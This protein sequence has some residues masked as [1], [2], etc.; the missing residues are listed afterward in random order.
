MSQSHIVLHL[1]HW[2]ENS[3]LICSHSLF[4]WRCR[5]Y[6]CEMAALAESTANSDSNI[7]TATA[8]EALNT[9]DT[10]QSIYRMSQYRFECDTISVHHFNVSDGAIT[11]P[12][13][14]RFAFSKWILLKLC[15]FRFNLWIH[16]NRSIKCITVCW[17]RHKIQ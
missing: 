2:M 8:V 16:M 10:N 13:K 7:T 14:S 6:C 12:A 5:R 4:Q 1:P 9:N 17:L 3:T 15:D 11:L